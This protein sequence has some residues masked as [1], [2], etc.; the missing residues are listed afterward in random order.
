MPDKDDKLIFEAYSDNNQQITRAAEFALQAIKEIDN[1]YKEQTEELKQQFD[2]ISREEFNRK[3][4]AL[5]AENSNREKEA[6]KKV[7][8]EHMP[9]DPY[10]NET[11]RP[12]EA[13]FVRL[14]NASEPSAEA[15]GDSLFDFAVHLFGGEE[16]AA[17]E[18]RRISMIAHGIG[19]F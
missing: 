16:A 9:A 1:W 10:D 12:S 18:L 5:L 6:I 15:M 11:F 7:I 2:T 4:R 3:L 19:M 17:H 8:A 13:L 14:S